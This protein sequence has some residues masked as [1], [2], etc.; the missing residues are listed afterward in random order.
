M[1][2]AVVLLASVAMAS[3][4][5]VVVRQD[6]SRQ[7]FLEMVC[8]KSGEVVTNSSLTFPFTWPYVQMSTDAASGLTYLA[9]FPDGY[10]YPVLY[11]LDR[12]L[13]VEY[14]WE[15]NKFTFW[16]MQY[17]PTQSTL[18]GILVTE[19]FNGGM[20]GRTLSNYTASV[21]T[22]E[23]TAVELYTL[24]YMVSVASELNQLNES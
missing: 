1:I 11:R 21:V 20:Y 3:S 6:D 13:N 22:G 19:D 4:A 14:A 15:N 12:D 5:V 16:D 8:G 24:P 23:I 7:G 17:S 10:S 2:R 18:Y 9:A